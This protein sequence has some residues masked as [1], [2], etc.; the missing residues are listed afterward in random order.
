MGITGGGGASSAPARQHGAPSRRESAL[1]YFCP[2]LLTYVLAC[3]RIS[4]LGLAHPNPN[5]SLTLALTLALS[6]ALS[7]ALTLAYLRIRAILANSL[8]SYFSQSCLALAE[9]EG[10]HTCL[11]TGERQGEVSG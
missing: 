7:L 5:P 4:R 6:L 1:A 11:A 3:L 2:C 8:R 10:L 9:C